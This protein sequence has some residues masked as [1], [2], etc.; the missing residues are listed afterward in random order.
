MNP[1]EFAIEFGV[2]RET[3]D[4]LQVYASLLTRWNRRINLVSPA[5]IADIWVRHIAD[6]AQ[7]LGLAHPQAETWI[8]LGTGAGL[9][10]LVIAVIAAETHPRLSLTLVESD[11]R[12]AAFLAEAARATGVFVAIETTR[13]ESLPP[14]P[15]DVI[16]ARALAPLPRLLELAFPFVGTDTMLLF[17]K[18]A[19]LD[20]ELTA[21]SANWHSRAERIVSRTDPAATVLKLR[22]LRPRS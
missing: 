13:I 3:T 14:A 18:G 8:D 5:T 4:R 12:K 21:A 2:S 7:L 6:S 10:G 15:F 11:T 1:N 17:P 20:S 19:R 22:E 16:S 9:P